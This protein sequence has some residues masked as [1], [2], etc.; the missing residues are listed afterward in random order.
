MSKVNPVVKL[1]K[2]VVIS[3]SLGSRTGKVNRSYLRS[4]ASAMDSF[5]KHKNASLKKVTRDSSSDE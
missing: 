1:P 4:M 5:E 3:A 2:N